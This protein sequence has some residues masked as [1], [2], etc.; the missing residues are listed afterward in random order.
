MY[1]ACE[2][3]SASFE[4]RTA[5]TAWPTSVQNGRRAVVGRSASYE[6]KKAR[7]SGGS[8]SIT[9]SASRTSARCQIGTPSAS[10]SLVSAVSR[11]SDSVSSVGAYDASIVHVRW[12]R[13]S[14]TAHSGC[15][16]CTVLSTSAATR[17]RSRNTKGARPRK[18]R[19]CDARQRWTTS[20]AKGTGVG[21]VADAGGSHCAG[22]PPARRQRS[23]TAR[24]AQRAATVSSSS[25]GFGSRSAEPP[26]VVAIA[27]FE[28]SPS[29]PGSRSTASRRRETN[30]CI[31]A[32]AVLRIVG[33]RA[34][35]SE[36]QRTRSC[37]T[38]ASAWRSA[39]D[40]A[41]V[42]TVCSTLSSAF[43]SSYGDCARAISCE[44]TAG[45]W[46]GASAACEIIRCTAP[47]AICGS[48]SDFEASASMK[49][50]STSC[51]AATAAP[52]SA[53]DA[54]GGS[55][56]CTERSATIA[57]SAASLTSA[58]RRRASFESARKS[59]SM[60]WMSWRVDI[61][62]RARIARRRPPR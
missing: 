13:R 61:V 60:R 58:K 44:I 9:R 27:S 22:S 39:G 31:V 4:R 1:S 59:C 56:A 49:G 40:D 54:D 12:A 10:S 38:V 21:P 14:A 55:F 28:G 29:P 3:R 6:R 18:R 37:E 48:V 20:S 52:C 15:G 41:I 23:C 35:W 51:D 32:D 5:W 8:C 24:K 34:F 17:S 11:T 30:C 2:W 16:C 25:F 47:S 45:I 53:G 62:W 7:R 50:I 42:S 36:R 43:S 19:P 26:G 46:C 57:R 33:A